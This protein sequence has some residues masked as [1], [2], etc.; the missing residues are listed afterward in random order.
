MAM[1]G[2]RTTYN[3]AATGPAGS[4]LGAGY[5]GTVGNHMTVRDYGAMVEPFFGPPSKPIADN[6]D[7]RY[8]HEAFFLQDAYN[9]R[10]DYIRQ[11]IVYAVVNQNSFMTKYILPWR[12][13]D[14]PNIAWEKVQ[15]NRTLMDLEPEQGVPR[16]V[17]V[18]KEAHSDKMVRRGLALI[19]NH[20]FAA[21]PGG[22]NDWAWKMATIAGAMQ[23]T[24][25]QDGLLTLLGCKDT[26]KALRIPPAYGAAEKAA[27]KTRQED[28]ELFQFGIV[29][30]EDRGWISLDAEA[31]YEMRL[32]HVQPDSWIV[33]PRMLN[34]VALGQPAET[35]YYRA[36]EEA[37]A[38]LRRGGDNFATFRGKK[39][40]E[41][42]PYNLDVDGRA[43]DPLTRERMIGDYF[44]EL[45]GEGRTE[46][47][48]CANDKFQSRKGSE[49]P[50]DGGHTAAP[51]DATPDMH[52]WMQGIQRQLAQQNERI[53]T[54]TEG[55]I[56]ESRYLQTLIGFAQNSREMMTLEI[57]KLQADMSKSLQENNIFLKYNIAAKDKGGV[58]S[59][60]FAY[61]LKMTGN[62]TLF[63]K[64]APMLTVPLLALAYVRNWVTYST[65]TSLKFEPKFMKMVA[66]PYHH[67]TVGLKDL[68]KIAD[69]ELRQFEAPFLPAD[70]HLEMIGLAASVDQAA[71]PEITVEQMIWFHFWT[72]EFVSAGAA[73]LVPL[74]L[75]QSETVE[76]LR[77]G[78]V[79]FFQ[80]ALIRPFG[81]FDQELVDRLGTPP[82]SVIADSC[83]ANLFLLRTTLIEPENTPRKS[84]SYGVPYECIM[85]QLLSTKILLQAME[86][87]QGPLP[88]ARRKAADWHKFD[89][90]GR[91]EDLIMHSVNGDDITPSNLKLT[92][93]Q[94]ACLFVFTGFEDDPLLRSKLKPRCMAQAISSVY[95]AETALGGVNDIGLF[96]ETNRGDMTPEELEG[97][98]KL[99]SEDCSRAKALMRRLNGPYGEVGLEFEQDVMEGLARGGTNF[100][101]FGNVGATI[102][103]GARAC[104]NDETW[105]NAIGV[106]KVEHSYFKCFRSGEA[107]TALREI[108]VRAMLA[109]DTGTV[110]RAN[111]ATKY[112]ENHARLP[113]H[114]AVRTAV[115]DAL[116][117]SSGSVPPLESWARELSA[118]QLSAFATQPAA[119]HLLIDRL[120]T[121]FRAKHAELAMHTTADEQ[122]CQ[123]AAEEVTSMKGSVMCK[124]GGAASPFEQT[125]RKVM[126]GVA[127]ELTTA[128]KK[129][130]AEHQAADKGRQTNAAI[131]VAVALCKE[132]I[133][134]DVVAPLCPVNAGGL[135]PGVPGV[136]RRIKAILCFRPFRR[137][138]MGTGILCQ[139]G[140]A[141]GNTFRGH[142]DFQMTDNIIAKTHIGHYT[143][144]HKAVVVDDRRL[145][146][147]EDMFC[148]GYAGGECNKG[149]EFPQ[150]SGDRH[151]FKEDPVGWMEDP[152]RGASILFLRVTLKSVS[153]LPRS[154]DLCNLVE[155]FKEHDI[156]LKST[157]SSRRYP[158]EAVA[159]EEFSPP[160]TAD[161]LGSH[162][163]SSPFVSWIEDAFRSMNSA[164]DMEAEG[165][166]LSAGGTVNAL[167]FRTMEVAVDN[168]GHRHIRTLNQGHFGVNGC[169][170]GARR[171]RSGFIETFKDCKYEQTYLSRGAPH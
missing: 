40:F 79:K 52:R 36:G 73:T 108:N 25:D 153:S 103:P 95:A 59:D 133:Q 137:Y 120:S 157:V 16:Y 166:Y 44:V 92:S 27:S 116:V 126:E 54:N 26:Y 129:A 82:L 163:M 146:L 167:C 21:T 70:L 96:F 107:A 121:A 58:V 78:L 112:I 74:N 150:N 51:G 118:S 87:G 15:F 145:Y 6:T 127:L 72:A 28:R 135:P 124:I 98:R 67:E 131:A 3:N 62:G 1:P 35:E 115:A 138:D 147:A 128:N 81:P 64:L 46:F 114:D 76:D 91:V 169:Y 106:D 136:G 53:S 77:G 11:T 69:L 142:E 7:S 110:I 22:Q 156:Q 94:A 97:A 37:R 90:A 71:I 5:P 56:V 113:A 105:G 119:E 101:R 2:A 85:H 9:G 80:D 34:F 102:G 164:Y 134:R 161:E 31:E 159:P 18:E 160:K 152:K 38:N 66:C 61:C 24:C 19:V 144:W 43:L 57:E 162:S 33:P 122:P 139:S 140:E 141:L 86:L 99:A 117:E 39:V 17:T 42:K 89:D 41:T 29:Q 23:E 55:A 48:C 149:C 60:L 83:I 8:P 63:V 30:R 132:A 171:P 154:F 100:L 12:N 130:E 125:R 88:R 75:L 104:V 65:F 109:G 123:S 13:Q 50:P 170:E 4:A 148:S 93:V 49:E 20:G 10:N 168:V 45:P 32:Q 155:E 151:D 165:N 68:F 84:T 143:M 158:S 47:Y 14:N 111:Q